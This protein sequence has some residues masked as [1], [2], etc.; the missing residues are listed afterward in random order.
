[1]LV[2]QRVLYLLKMVIVH[3]HVRLFPEGNS[4]VRRK[5]CQPRRIEI[6]IQHYPYCGVIG[7]SRI[8]TF[9]E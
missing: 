7:G 2:Y 6:G 8:A 1:M 9:M 4:K 3:C 5:R